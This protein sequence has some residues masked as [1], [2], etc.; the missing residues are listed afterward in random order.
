MITVINIFF[1]FSLLCLASLSQV[2][3][4]QYDWHIDA[5]RVYD[6]SLVYITC[7]TLSMSF[8]NNYAFAAA[9]LFLLAGFLGL[10]IFAFGGGWSYITEP[11]FG[12]LLGLL[13]LSISAFYLKY[14]QENSESEAESLEHT[15]CFRPLIAIGLAHIIGM[16]FLL[17][18]GR[19]NLTNFLNFSLYQIIFDLSFAYFVLIILSKFNK[20]TDVL[21]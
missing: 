15:V 11:S 4:L 21:G 10:P 5:F 19:F 1:C 16:A 9:V 18:T 20:N 6:Y 2:P 7:F 3:L 17:I 12:Y 8:R 14:H 13:A